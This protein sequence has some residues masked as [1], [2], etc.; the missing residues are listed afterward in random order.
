[1]KFGWKNCVKKKR[2]V[3]AESFLCGLFLCGVKVFCST[4]CV[5]EDLL[6][7]YYLCCLRVGK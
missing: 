6:I 7:T 2:V 5:L 4:T 3:F 1:M